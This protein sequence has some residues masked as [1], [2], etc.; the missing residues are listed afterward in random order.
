M[1]VMCGIAQ[2]DFITQMSLQHACTCPFRID[3]EEVLFFPFHIG[4]VMMRFI[5]ERLVI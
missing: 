4:K 5:L 3:F 2:G 1:H